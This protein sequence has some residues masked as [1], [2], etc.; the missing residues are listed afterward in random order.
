MS[1]SSVVSATLES[2]D[3]YVVY[4]VVVK[5]AAG[6]QSEVIVDAGNGTVLKTEIRP[7]RPRPAGSG[8]DANAGTSPPWACPAFVAVRPAVGTCSR[9]LWRDETRSAGS[10]SVQDSR[11]TISGMTSLVAAPAD[12]CAESA[13]QAGRLMGVLRSAAVLLLA[14]VLAWWLI[15]AAAAT[16]WSGIAVLL[17]SVTTLKVA[18]LVILWAVGLFLH[19]YV[20]TSSLPGLS[21]RRALTLNLT[22]SAVSNLLPAG[23]A[24]GVATNLVMMR[25]WAVPLTSFT[26]FTVVSNVWDVAAKL[27]LPAVAVALV[28]AGGA[29]LPPLLLG[30]AA[31]AVLALV[32]A[33]ATI[34]A[35]A[36]RPVSDPPPPPLATALEQHDAR[37]RHLVLSWLDRAVGATRGAW[38]LALRTAGARWPQLTAGMVGY[39]AAQA[40]LLWACFAALGSPVA[41][42]VVV[43]A[44]AVER[45]TTLVP[46]T[47]SGVGLAEAG[48]VSVLVALGCAPAVAAAGVLLYRLFTV[49]LEIPVGALWLAAWSQATTR[50]RS[51]A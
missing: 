17:L 41:I 46:I 21:H 11:C 31:V 13:P 33:L 3:G 36:R 35:V 7:I 43:A 47:P 23:G 51:T 1:G 50:P 12:S 19:S 9:L 15:P 26:A 10:G 37:P 5:D 20:L 8:R 22:G 4:E 6:I 25:R 18:G 44:F 40:A 14:V 32:T 27:L 2:E 29:V 45:L 28:L 38:P 34:W 49:V 30:G 16:P 48:A 42:T 39:L 24:A